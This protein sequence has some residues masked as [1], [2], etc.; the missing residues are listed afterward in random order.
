MMTPSFFTTKCLKALEGG[1]STGLSPR[2]RRY[3]KWPNNCLRFRD[4]NWCRYP[5]WRERIR[6]LR[7]RRP[8]S[9]FLQCWRRCWL[10]INYWLSALCRHNPTARKCVW[11][12]FSWL[13]NSG[14]VWHCY[15]PRRKFKLRT[16]CRF[17]GHIFNSERSRLVHL[18][19][20]GDISQKDVVG[21][22]WNRLSIQP[23]T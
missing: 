1:L 7:S 23:K 10:R 11:L 16:N 19:V 3:R 8:R 15:L 21:G 17:A 14:N 5:G 4:G 13:S 22:R 2:Q 9:G 18:R 20:G 6:Y 12:P